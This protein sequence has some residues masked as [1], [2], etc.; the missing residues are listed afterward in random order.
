MG[1][2]VP[3]TRRRSAVCRLALGNSLQTPCGQRP[4]EG[5]VASD[6]LKKKALQKQG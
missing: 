4:S 3:G 2:G 5:R 6:C 1:S